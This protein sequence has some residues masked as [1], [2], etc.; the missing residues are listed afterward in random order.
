MP[1][2]KKRHPVKVPCVCECALQFKISNKYYWCGIKP[3]VV[4]VR[5]GLLANP[6]HQVTGQWLGHE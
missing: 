5:I 6:V 1:L 4:M 3:L 2:N